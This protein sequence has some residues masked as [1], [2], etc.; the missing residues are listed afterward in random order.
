MVN[1]ANLFPRVEKYSG[2]MKEIV[3]L[4]FRSPEAVDTINGWVSRKPGEGYL[5]FLR[6]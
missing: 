4:D 5:G 2:K 3:S 1:T 6:S